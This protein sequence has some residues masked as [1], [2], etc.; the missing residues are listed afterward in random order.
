MAFQYR[1]EAI[2]RLQHS[3]EKQEENRLLACVAQ[4]TSLRNEIEAWEVER[5]N[6]KRQSAEELKAGSTG[7]ALSIAADWDVH[8]TRK[9]C[10]IGALLVKAEEVRR[11]QVVKVQQERQKREVLEGLKDR[12]ET[13][14]DQ[15]E[16]RRLQ[17]VLDDM[18][19]TRAFFYKG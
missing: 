11:T 14:Y 10:E 1:L 2:L 7:V 13:V 9:Q 15:E 19:L 17:Q 16:L 6:R 18:H 5:R 8:V 3:I 4:V 12:L